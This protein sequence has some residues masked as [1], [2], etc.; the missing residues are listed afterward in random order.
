MP[1]HTEML[2]LR[3][4]PG[5]WTVLAG[6]VLVMSLSPGPAAHAGD[7]GLLDDVTE[8]AGTVT[9]PVV[10]PVVEAVQTVVPPV[11]QAVEPVVEDVVQPTVSEVEHAVDEATGD[12]RGAPP[13]G[14]APARV[15]DDGPGDGP[16]G[17]PVA[18]A[19]EPVT[20]SQPAAATLT[21]APTGPGSG[22]STSGARRGDEP[23]SAAA[24]RSRERQRPSA[25]CD[26]VS[27]LPP[28]GA[29][30]PVVQDRDARDAEVAGSSR[31]DTRLDDR[32]AGGR[33][34]VLPGH[35]GPAPALVAPDAAR[36]LWLAG[37]VALVMMLTAGLTVVLVRELE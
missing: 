30:A 17:E 25:A 13:E 22:H 27:G 36:A 16:H 34:F 2:L 29:A 32:S 5:R 11:E 3:H 37:L 15:E 8:V 21:T 26:G 1:D 28:R 20:A 14:E 24:D 4:R 23:R 31:R 19:A 33:T 10:E 35:G 12:D 6:V 9:D 7:G 18:E